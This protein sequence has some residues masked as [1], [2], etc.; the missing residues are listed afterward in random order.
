MSLVRAQTKARARDALAGNYFRAALIMLI[1]FLLSL[2]LTELENGYRKVFDI[3][4]NLSSGLIN[5]APESFAI[6]FVS[7]LL[8]ILLV[9]PLILGQTEWYWNLSEKKPHG[10]DEVFGWFGSL[11]LYKKSVLIRINVF[12]RSFLWYLLICGLPSAMIII[13]QYILNYTDSFEQYSQQLSAVYL[14]GLVLMVAGVVL[15]LFV[16]TRYFLA[17][18]IIVEDSSRGVNSAIRESVALT[19]GY[20]WEIIKF[21]LSFIPWFLSLVVIVTL[22][23]VYP[24]FN[25]SAAIF[26]KHIIYTQRAKKSKVNLD[27]E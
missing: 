20:R 7:W 5:L 2:G 16:I 6:T 27:S 12:I 25:E 14:A 22:F 24:Y 9:S 19:K 1:L 23:F 13:P 10:I 21:V 17:V 15:W 11:R 26:A 8:S 4:Y 18:Y 3:P